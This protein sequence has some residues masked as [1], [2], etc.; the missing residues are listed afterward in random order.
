L[1]CLYCCLHLA[2]LTVRDHN[3]AAAAAA[4]EG[5]S[6]RWWCYALLP[7]LSLLL[8]TRLQHTP[9]QLP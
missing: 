5:M 4:V 7:G 9:N 2:L 3:A 1:Y 6:H 8:N